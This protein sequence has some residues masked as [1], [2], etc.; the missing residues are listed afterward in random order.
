MSDLDDAAMPADDERLDGLISFLDASPSPWHAAATSAG[1]LTEAGFTPLRITDDWTEL[2]PA[3]FVTVGA[4]LLAYRLADAP[5]PTTPFRIIG[6]HTDSPCLRV[7]PRP[8]VGSNGWRQLGVEVYGG[9]LLNS[10]L[11][12]DLGI[13]G[14]VVLRD[15]SA[16]DVCN[17]EAIC[18]VPQ[19]AIHLDREVND[20]GLVLDKQQHLTPVWGSGVAR[21]GDFREWLAEQIDI[22]PV[23]V[24]WWKL[25]LFDRTAAAVL[26]GDGSLLALH[27]G[28][29]PDTNDHGMGVHQ[30]D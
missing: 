21:E 15:G 11:D 23:D 2:P 24:A 26:G 7:K 28:I 17:D 9:V 18:R 14:R 20:R 6:A 25:C 19:L 13:A 30:L 29:D 22:S 1:R 5:T 16:I 3:G 27:G 4:S 12:R 10:W 8:D